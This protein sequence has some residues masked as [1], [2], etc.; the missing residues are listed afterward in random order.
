M[1]NLFIWSFHFFR[2]KYPQGTYFISPKLHLLEDFG[3]FI[4]YLAPCGLGYYFSHMTCKQGLSERRKIW[5][6][7]DDKSKTRLL[8]QLSARSVVWNQTYQFNQFSTKFLMSG[9]RLFT[10]NRQA[11][12]LFELNVAVQQL[13]WCQR[14]SAILL[15]CVFRNLE[16]SKF[17][18]SSCPVFGYS[19]YIELP[20]R[21]PKKRTENIL[22]SNFW[23]NFLTSYGK[24]LWDL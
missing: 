19:K 24:C 22:M 4:C 23:S 6:W 21:V 15:F 11:T 17:W 18:T 1:F 7:H 3:L 5:Y 16:R 14:K 13:R 12:L 9:V 10:N 20:K 8:S 2:G